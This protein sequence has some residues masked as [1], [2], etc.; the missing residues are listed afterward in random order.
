[1]RELPTV[2]LRDEDER[3]IAKNLWWGMGL[4]GSPKLFMKLVGDPHHTCQTLQCTGN[5]L[6]SGYSTSNISTAIPTAQFRCTAH[7]PVL[8]CLCFAFCIERLSLGNEF[9]VC[10]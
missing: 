5:K 4:R 2:E 7:V 10:R 8:K 1:V 6:R 9:P 3:A